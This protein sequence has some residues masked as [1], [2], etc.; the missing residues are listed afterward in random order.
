MCALKV[1]GKG[2]IESSLFNPSLPELPDPFVAMV[3]KKLSDHDLVNMTKLNRAWCAFI[4]NYDSLSCLFI[5]LV[6][7]CSKKLSIQISGH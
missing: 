2:I 4:F 5:S 6:R 1:E 3:L 7:L